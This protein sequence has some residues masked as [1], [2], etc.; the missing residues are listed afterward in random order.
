[1]YAISQPIDQP[2]VVKPINTL[3]LDLT[4]SSTAKAVNI[5]NKIPIENL[6]IIKSIMF[7]KFCKITKSPRLE[8][9]TR[10]ILYF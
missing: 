6:T 8:N 7:K 5:P 4:A 1:M 3:F 2:A 9:T 10:E